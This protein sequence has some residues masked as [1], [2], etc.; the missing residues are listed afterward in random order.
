MSDISRT[1]NERVQRE[2]R[3]EVGFSCPAPSPN[4]IGRCGNPYLTWHHFD[5][6]WNVRHH[7][8]PR[9]MIALCL[10]HHKKADYGA[11]TKDQ[12]R[13]FKEQASN[14]FRKVRGKF[15]W[16]RHKLLAVVG[17]NF[18]YETAIVFQYYETPII[19]FE[20]NE[21][22][23]LLLNIDL[24]SVTSNLQLQMRNN[25]WQVYGNPDDIEC[26]PSGKKIH[27]KYENGDSVRIEFVNIES[28][29]KFQKKYSSTPGIHFPLVIVEV[30]MTIGEANLQFGPKET[31]LAS[32]TY[33]GNRVENYPVALLL[34]DKGITLGAVV[35]PLGSP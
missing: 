33:S 13:Q 25:I 21:Q 19:W 24:H 6:P 9:G 3:R 2:L 20:R 11:Y 28:V 31:I 26:P 35:H 22:G 34:N 5:P 23:Y 15:E 17:G 30:H 12:L 8:N 29:S 18:Y 16:M 14:R 1:P 4:N 32:N 10:E 27:V 7:H